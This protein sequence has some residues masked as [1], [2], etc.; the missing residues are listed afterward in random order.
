MTGNTTTKNISR[1]IK[2]EIDPELITT[3]YSNEN[4]RWEDDG[5]QI[6]DTLQ[7]IDN[8]LLP[9]K[10][11]D[12]FKVIEGHLFEENGRIYFVTEVEFLN[13]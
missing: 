3:P 11:G 7:M 12:T 10:P 13:K 9:L 4:I 8:S 2:I 6:P 1:Q 5:G